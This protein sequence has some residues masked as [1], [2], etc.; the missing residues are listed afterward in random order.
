MTFTYLLE[1]FLQ[2]GT[3]PIQALDNG[4]TIVE[5]ELLPQ[6][7][8]HF[9]YKIR[10]CVFGDQKWKDKML[11]VVCNS[12]T[13]EIGC[14]QGFRFWYGPGESSNG[15]V[16]RRRS[17]FQISHIN[18]ELR[19]PTSSYHIVRRSNQDEDTTNVLCLRSSHT[20]G[21]GATRLAGLLQ[22]AGLG[23]E[24]FKMREKAPLMM[25]FWAKNGMPVTVNVGTQQNGQ[26]SG[27]N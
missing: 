11:K 3:V 1:S 17:F 4:S 27:S 18:L 13:F 23:Y 16:P 25:F 2:Q 14:E 7:L 24:L 9:D 10:R 8:N 20:S 15:E 22:E 26:A 5:G 19:Y 12:N 6:L 21:P